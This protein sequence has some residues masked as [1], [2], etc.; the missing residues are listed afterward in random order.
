MKP[1][2]NND[3]GKACIFDPYRRK[4]VSATPEE[5]VRQNFC[6]YLVK[7]KGYPAV[8]IAN[9]FVVNVNGQQQRCDTLI[10][11]NQKAFMLV[12]YKSPN[13]KITQDVFDQLIRYNNTIRATY[14]VVC[15]GKENF[16]CSLDYATNSSKFLKEIPSWEMVEK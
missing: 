4:Y 3:K 16:C 8:L 7:E 9:E 12:E 6:A 11:K 15:N 2:I 14:L 5:I 13:V 10:Q 1:I